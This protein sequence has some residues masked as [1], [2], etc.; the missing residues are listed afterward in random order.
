VRG[1]RFRGDR[2]H[3][4]V[5]VGVLTAG[6]I[7][8][9]KLSWTAY[10]RGAPVLVAEEYWTVTRD[11]VDWPELPDEQFLARV[12]VEGAPPIRLHLTIGNDPVDE[13]TGSSGGQL[14]V[15]MTAVRAIPYVLQAPPGVG[16]TPGFGAYRW[17]KRRSTTRVACTS[18]NGACTRPPFSHGSI[19][20]KR[21]S[22]AR[23]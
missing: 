4:P 14:A 20:R 3:G 8:V 16:T 2:R 6:T 10:H 19:A 22:G 21:S 13:L 7:V 5:A 9:H 11:V 17:R 18:Q 15:A 12:R 23:A 1:Q